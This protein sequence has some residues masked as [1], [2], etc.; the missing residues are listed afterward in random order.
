MTA[1]SVHLGDLGQ[2]L[3]P[4]PEPVDAIPVATKIRST[5]LMASIQA[6][7]QHGWFDAYQAAVPREVLDAIQTSVAGAWLPMELAVAHYGACDTLGVSLLEQLDIGG[8]VVRR[9]QQTLLGKLVKV[10][11]KAGTLSPLTALRRFNQ[12]HAR[13]WVGSAGQVVELGPKDVRLDVVGLPLVH[14][15]YFRASYRG[16]LRA[17]A[18]LFTKSA[19]VTEVA[20]ERYEDAVS[21]RFAWV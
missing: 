4:F 3:V 6:L 9:L 8:A 11:H 7:R 19:F 16:F 21:Y 20:Q 17:G 18:Q 15:P 10:A 1:T 2:I 13:S 12:L 5:V 14:I